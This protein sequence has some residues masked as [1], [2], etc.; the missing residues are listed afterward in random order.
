MNI[1]AI[2]ISIVVC[3]ALFAILCSLIHE[4][5][6]QTKAE[7]GR[8]MKKYILQQLEDLPNGINWGTLLYTHGSID[9]LSRAVNKPTSS[10]PPKLFAETLIEVVGNTQLVQM[11]L[12]EVATKLTYEHPVLRNFQ[13]A[14]QTL[15][16]SDVVS[17]FK[18][19]LNS[20]ELNSQQEQA[21]DASQVYINL[22]AAVEAWYNELSD[23]MT[24]WYQKK[25]R[26]R[27]FIVGI[28]TALIINVDSVQ[29]F[30]IFNNS[31]DARNAV[32]TYYKQHGDELSNY[33]KKIDATNSGSDSLGTVA[34]L[35]ETNVYLSKMD[36]LSK[37]AQLP[38]GVQYNVFHRPKNDKWDWYLLKILG[39]LI[40]G[41]AASFGAPFWFD[42]LK[43]AYTT[44]KP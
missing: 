22:V 15:H 16:P 24:L 34:I 40:S 18:Q 8:F 17:F 38:I 27:L 36:S 39:I 3:W 42:L 10:I 1:L 4:A 14:I 9:L 13:A 23:R 19:S 20:A 25:T 7:R 33:A 32:L 2:A 41:F 12:P 21:T 28:I 35:K 6:A 5:V 26:V 29:L 37:Q 44:A 31:S 11:K 43:K 30:S